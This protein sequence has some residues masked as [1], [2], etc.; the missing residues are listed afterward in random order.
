VEE[1]ETSAEIEVVHLR[2]LDSMA[3]AYPFLIRARIQGVDGEGVVHL[4][5][6]LENVLFRAKLRRG[7]A[8]IQTRLNHLLQKHSGT[9]FAEGVATDV[10]KELRNEHG[11]WGYWSD[12][13]FDE[14]LNSGYFYGKPVDN[15]LLWRYEEWLV[16]RSGYGHSLK[17][18]A[19]HRI[20]HEAIE[21]IAPQTESPGEAVANGYG[22]YDVVEPA[23]NG[24]RS[25]EWLN[26]LGNLV[27]ISRSDNSSYGNCAFADKLA[28][29][30]KDNLLH[31][32]KEIE[33]FVAD[34][35]KP[36]WDWE[37]IDR[38]QNRLVTAAKEI[39]S[40]DFI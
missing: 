7:R 31:Q 32:Q 22:A 21:H 4:A 9:G 27:L 40:L 20:P 14:E 15:Y 6:A 11:W 23:N 30:G 2:A 24:I 10:A 18:G 26:C 19:I 3:F 34:P 16:A 8:E 39:W 35:Q 13:V 36:V 38:R 28:G 5:R 17:I 29:Y 12:K 25:G 37:A 33:K 1:I